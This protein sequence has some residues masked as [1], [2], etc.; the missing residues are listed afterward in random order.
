[1]KI[2]RN[3]KKQKK[4]HDKVEENNSSEKENKDKK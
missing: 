2:V 1:M 3:P 4:L